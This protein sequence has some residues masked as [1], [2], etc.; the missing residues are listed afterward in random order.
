M[1]S[2]QKILDSIYACTPATEAQFNEFLVRGLIV[3]VGPG[4]LYTNWTWNIER[5]RFYEED[6][7]KNIFQEIVDE[8][9]KAKE[10]V[11]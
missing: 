11:L 2:K 5:M 4:H 1:T 6:A 10:P 8:N 3:R 9:A 7:L